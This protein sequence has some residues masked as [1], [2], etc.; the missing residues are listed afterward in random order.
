MVAEAS[1][2]C[3][4]PRVRVT[5]SGPGVRRREAFARPPKLH[6]IMSFQGSASFEKGETVASEG[7]QQRFHAAV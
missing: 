1:L 2:L 4:E 5:T 7:R 3:N 6:L